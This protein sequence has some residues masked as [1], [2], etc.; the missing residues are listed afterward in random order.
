[1]NP[2]TPIDVLTRQEYAEATVIRIGVRILRETEGEPLR[3]RDNLYREAEAGNRPLIL[4]FGA[5]EVLTSA[6][7][8]WLI[9]LRKKLMQRG[10]PFQPPCRRRG[11]FAIFPDE[12]QALEAIRT[13]ERDPL[14]LCSLRPEVMEVFQVCGA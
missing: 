8:G 4:D 9:T 13:G 6:V 5:V 7:L 1:M 14:L 11:L 3:L 2:K 10:T 12:T